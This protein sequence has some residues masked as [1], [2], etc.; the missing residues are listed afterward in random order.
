M[1]DP[2]IAA[3]AFHIVVSQGILNTPNGTRGRWKILYKS[4]AAR[5]RRWVP[6]RLQS[7]AERFWDVQL[8]NRDALD[9]LD[10]K[11][12]RCSDLLR[13]AILHIRHNTIST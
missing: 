13:S 9:V 3:W 12:K 10:M 1:S 4:H 7:L 11:C 2:L 8:E 5:T 6:G